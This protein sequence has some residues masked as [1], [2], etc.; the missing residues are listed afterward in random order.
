VQNLLLSLWS[1]GLPSKWS[2]GSITRT[3]SFRQLVDAKPDE[4]V[5][6]LIMTGYPISKVIKNNF[7]KTITLGGR[8]VKRD[9]VGNIL[10]E[11]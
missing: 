5:V 2:T 7:T 1:E 3:T 6:G 8:K 4:L 9:I 10:H 11:L